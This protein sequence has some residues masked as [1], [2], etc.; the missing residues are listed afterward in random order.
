MKKLSTQKL[1]LIGFCIGLNVVGAFIA[2]VT[3]IPLLFD[4]IGTIMVSAFL[5]PVYGIITGLAGSL[6]NGLTYDVYALYFSPVQ[7]A[8]GLIA[9]ILYKRH[10][11]QGKKAFLGT[12]A[13]SLVSA[14]M[15]AVIAA[16]VFD[17]VTSSG[18]T[19]IVQL[20]SVFGVSKVI[21]VFVTQFLMDYADRLIAVIVV[22]SIITRMPKE[23]K[24]K[25]MD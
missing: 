9:G 15:G 21:S 5:G 24:K 11:I 14:F 23:L 17:G 7:I 25:L 10:M 13:I 4:S 19:Y 3:Q 8:V 12:M 2:I 16:Y 6:I 1:T 22:N 18:S 20:L